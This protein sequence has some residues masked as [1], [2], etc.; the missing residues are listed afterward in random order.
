MYSTSGPVQ[1]QAFLAG[2]PTP[3]SKSCGT[4]ALKRYLLLFSV[5]MAELENGAQKRK[6][7]AQFKIVITPQRVIQIVRKYLRRTRIEKVY[8]SDRK[9]ITKCFIFFPARIRSFSQ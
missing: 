1:H 3:W 6:L 8:R 7:R 5:Y 9:R 4:V 2:L